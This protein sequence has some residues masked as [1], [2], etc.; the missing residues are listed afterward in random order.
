MWLN[1]GGNLT[2]SC[3][4]NDALALV[5]NGPNSA[6]VFGAGT[7]LQI[8]AG[9]DQPAGRVTLIGGTADYL[10]TRINSNC[11]VFLQ[12]KAVNGGAIGNLTYTISSGK[13]TV[14]SDNPADVSTVDFIYYRVQ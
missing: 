5:S 14:N 4:G 11:V 6:V 3:N 10:T 13:L 8:T 1:P 12:R 2:F 9:S 7:Q